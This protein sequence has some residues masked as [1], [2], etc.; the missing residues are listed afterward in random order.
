MPEEGRKRVIAA[1]LM[2]RGQPNGLKVRGSLYIKDSQIEKL[3]DGLT[4]GKDLNMDG[5]AVKEL[6]RGLR[7]GSS[8]YMIGTGITEIPEDAIIR[9]YVSSD[10]GVKI[11]KGVRLR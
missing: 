11:P 4:V 7:V 9:G 3:P 6:P 10:D 1:K 5:C 8:V 2:L